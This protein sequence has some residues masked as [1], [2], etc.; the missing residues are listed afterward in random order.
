MTNEELKEAFKKRIPVNH[1]GVEYKY[2][3]AVIYRIRSRK[4]VVL[5]ELMDRCGHSVVIVDADG[6]TALCTGPP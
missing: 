4:I 1:R 6:V 5:A 3:S 2:I